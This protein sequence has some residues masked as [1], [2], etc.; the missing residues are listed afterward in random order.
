M[1]PN[2]YRVKYSKYKGY[3]P[4]HYPEIVAENFDFNLINLAVPS[5]SNDQIY[6]SYI[7]NID[8]IKPND[9]LIFGWTFVSRYNLA[10]RDNQLE[11]ININREGEITFEDF[12]SSQSINEILYNRGSHTIFYKWVS[13]YI[14]SINKTFEN[15]IVLHY[16]FFPH[17]NVDEYVTEYLN[18]L[19]PRRM[20]YET[21]SEDT[22]GELDGHYSERGHLDFANDISKQIFTIYK[23]II[24]IV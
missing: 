16:D 11:N 3:Y 24:N 4:K 5:T 13:N 18:L 2:D 23:K 19:T 21:I 9:I 8:K 10:N 14:K 12:L 20:K 17:G 6:H 15:N 1:Y 7:E 22:K